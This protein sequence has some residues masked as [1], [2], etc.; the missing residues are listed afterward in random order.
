MAADLDKK[1]VSR[2]NG[3]SFGL[4]SLYGIYNLGVRYLHTILKERGYST[5]LIFFKHLLLN[6]VSI[7]TELEY[8]SLLELLEML[9]V[10]IVGISLGCSSFLVIA[11][12]L[13][14]RI[15]KDLG[16]PVIWGGVHP[17]I[18]PEECI[19]IADFVCIGE[20]E[21]ALLE[22]ISKLSEGK[23]IEDI[24]N[25]WIK[26]KNGRVIRNRLR[27]LIQNLDVLPFPD[28]SNNSKYFIEKNKVLTIDPFRISN[29]QYFTM[30]SR[31]CFYSCSYCIESVYKKYYKHGKTVR[32]R[33][34]ENIIAELRN[35][36]SLGIRQIA[37]FDEIFPLELSWVRDFSRHYKE[38]VDIP[39]WCYFH[40]LTVKDEILA[41]LKESGIDFVN[42]G[43]QSG[44]ERIRE[45]IFNRKESNRDII[46]AIKRIQ[47]YKITPCLDFIVD[48]PFDK[49]EDKQQTLELLFNLPQPFNLNLYSLLFFPGYNITEMGLREQLISEEDIEG[50]CGF[51]NLS[52]A[53]VVIGGDR[54]KGE[55]VFICLISLA[56][57]S[58]MPKSLICFLAHRKNITKF[59]YFNLIIILTMASMYVRWLKLSMK[60]LNKE[61]FNP[62]GVRKYWM[63]F[64]FYS[65]TIK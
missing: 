55:L 38:F 4:I 10:D 19:K 26:E 21:Y 59:P 17:T 22:F 40:P 28:Y 3:V 46:E 30:S 32:R 14:K 50:R 8:R 25:I 27:P 24:E 20:G 33:S 35:I 49:P 63:Y 53:F 15:K 44:S 57:K 51:N 6:D 60:F 41:L 56:A 65:K 7:P 52:K 29:L 39:F 48:N 1:I 2:P 64:K 16:I 47:K 11:T 18:Q 12:E 13:T 54:K 23:P 31:G 58:F 42:M 37:F 36:K 61:R 34:V 62:L 45:N 5:K 43:V 9:K